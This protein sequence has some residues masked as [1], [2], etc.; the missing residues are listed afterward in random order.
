MKNRDRHRGTETE[1]ETETH[2]GRDRDINRQRQTHK[3]SQTAAALPSAWLM[4]VS[5]STI[6]TPVV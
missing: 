2:K 1:K 6:F 5:P 4:A 3:G